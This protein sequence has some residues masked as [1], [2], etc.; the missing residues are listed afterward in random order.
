MKAGDGPR[1]AFRPLDG[2]DDLS[3]HLDEFGQRRNAL[4]GHPDAI[5]VRHLADCSIRPVA[6]YEA[7]DQKPV[8]DLIGVGGA[9]LI[10]C[11][12][13]IRWFAKKCGSILGGNCDD[14]Q[15]AHFHR[16]LLLWMDR[17]T[18]VS[19]LDAH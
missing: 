1:L 15:H 18:N 3:E 17:P 4:E 14:A 12:V 19:R 10:S 9:A 2:V 6:E 11:P 7:V 13:A 16:R 5:T 8:I